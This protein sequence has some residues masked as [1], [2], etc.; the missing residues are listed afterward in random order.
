MPN[1]RLEIKQKIK[2]SAIKGLTDHINELRNELDSCEQKLER[3]KKELAEL[4]P[5]SE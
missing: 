4:E 5:V 3:R 2:Q 1:E